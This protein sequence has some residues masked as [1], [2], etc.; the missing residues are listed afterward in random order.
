M[1]SLTVDGGRI[2][3]RGFIGEA[4][5]QSRLLLTP[6]YSFGS[7]SNLQDLAS[8]IILRNI[9]CK[10]SQESKSTSKPTI[11]LAYNDVCKHIDNSSGF[12]NFKLDLLFN[13]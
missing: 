11:E 13:I 6:G 4:F 3:L 5:K 8:A 12:C 1:I 10:L 7:C 9:V 2:H